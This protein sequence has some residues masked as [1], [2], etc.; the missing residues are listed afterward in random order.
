MGG[1]YRKRPLLTRTTAGSRT[2]PHPHIV[3]LRYTDVRIRKGARIKRAYVQFTV[4]DGSTRKSDSTI[5]AELS[6]NGK[7]FTEAKH[8]ISS[9]K[10]TKASVKWSPE[11]W[12]AVGERSEKQQTPDLSSLIQEVIAQDDWQ[13]GNALV[14]I[15]TGSGKREAVSF[16][17]GGRRYAPMLHLEVE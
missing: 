16:D 15:I 3:G 12:E 17:G 9:R 10:K 7:T 2:D 14:L 5:H 8:N 4:D 6:A 13:E 1:C 11:P